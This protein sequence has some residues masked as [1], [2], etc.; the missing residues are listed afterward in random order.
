MS[1]IT[2][3]LFG[4]PKK[5]I[6]KKPKVEHKP[7]KKFYFQEKEPQEKEPQKKKVIP[8]RLRKQQKE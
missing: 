7:V 2:T 8:L 1:A 5:E 4:L 3:Y 6:E